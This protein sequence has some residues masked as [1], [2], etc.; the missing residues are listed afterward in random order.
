M[1]RLLAVVALALLVSGCGSGDDG[2]PE[3]NAKATEGGSATALEDAREACGDVVLEAV[4]EGSS[5]ELGE[6]WA[7]N[8]LELGDGGESLTVHSPTDSAGDTAASLVAMLCVLE[9][10]D[11]PD[12]VQSEIEQ[13]SALM[14]RQEASWDD[15]ELTWSYHPDSGMSAVFTQGDG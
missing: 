12:S 6:A 15:L 11:A 2:D 7:D 9:E 4:S 8:W 14:G 5:E 13:T 3:T 1:K 10:T